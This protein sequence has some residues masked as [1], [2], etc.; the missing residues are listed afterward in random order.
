MIVIDDFLNDFD[1]LVK[2]K[3]SAIFNQE[4]NK[5]DGA[6]Y[7]AIN[8]DVP[9][10]IKTDFV[11]R[12]EDIK[13]FKIKPNLIFLRANP[14]GEIEPYQAHNDLNM[15]KYTCILYL[16]EHGGTAFLEHIETGMDRNDPDF[17]DV[18]SADCNNFDAWAVK[19]FCSMKPNR[20]LFFDAELMH[21]G[22][23]VEGYG[24]GSDSRMIMVCFYDKAENDS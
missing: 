4:I 22:E 24:V 7:P 18:W 13:G 8:F 1:S 5:V 23:P 14:L 6:I 12:I 16:T 11:K 17:A 2:Y 9:L 3:E 21:R 15:G 10:S 20:A 19:D